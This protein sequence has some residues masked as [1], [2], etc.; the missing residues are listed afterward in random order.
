MC[1]V[2]V[3]G[4]GLVEGLLLETHSTPQRQCRHYQSHVTIPPI[5]LVN[6]QTLSELSR[7]FDMNNYTAVTWCRCVA[8]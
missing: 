1:V 2:V 7:C 5:R 4:Q 6:L 8:H 3:S